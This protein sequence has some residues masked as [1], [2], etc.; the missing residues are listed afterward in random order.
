[1]VSS[2]IMMNFF[3][4]LMHFVVC[5]SRVYKPGVLPNPPFNYWAV[6]KRGLCPEGGGDQNAGCGYWKKLGYCAPDQAY[7]SFMADTCQASCGLCEARPTPAPRPFTVKVNIRECLKAHNSKRALHRAR[8]LIWDSLLAKKAQ[9][10][11]LTLAKKEKME[12]A[13]W[14]GAGENL[15]YG[16]NSGGKR[17]NCKEAV[18]AW[19]GEVSDYPFKNPPNTIWDNPRVQIGHFTQVVWKATKRVGVGIAVIKRGFLTKTYIVARY[20]PPGNYQ[21]QFKQQVGNSV[22]AL[23]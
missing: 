12:H 9:V 7:A 10:W 23:K 13:P 6:A 17:G 2:R 11:A 19:Y 14:S 18:E 15:F 21:G 20:S 3:L 4:V 16:A 1:M 8:P 22:F 5:K